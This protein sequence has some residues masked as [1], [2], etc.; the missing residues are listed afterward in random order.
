MKYRKYSPKKSSRSAWKG[1]EFPEWKLTLENRALLVLALV[2]G[3]IQISERNGMNLDFHS[4]QYTLKGSP[5]GVM[6][7]TPAQTG[8][9]DSQDGERPEMAEETH[10]SHLY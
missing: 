2:G 1:R 9:Q 4:S 6:P 7:C 5:Q 10:M 8:S 3:W